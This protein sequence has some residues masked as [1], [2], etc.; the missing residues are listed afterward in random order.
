MGHRAFLR[1]RKYNKVSAKSNFRSRMFSYVCVFV[2]EYPTLEPASRH[3]R[4]RV[5]ALRG[6]RTA[7]T[8]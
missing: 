1:V 3:R 8:Y 2:I 6:R 4:G 5:G 7:T